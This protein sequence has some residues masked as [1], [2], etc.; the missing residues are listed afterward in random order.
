MSDQVPVPISLELRAAFAKAVLA[1]EAWG[2]GGS[3]R[4]VRVGLEFLS[5]GAVCGLVDQ[6]SDEMQEH[7]FLKLRS[8]MHEHPHGELIARLAVLPTQTA[9]GASA[10]S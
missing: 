10:N 3:E 9:L 8:F 4:K 2:L 5:I 1:Y 6:F 7:V